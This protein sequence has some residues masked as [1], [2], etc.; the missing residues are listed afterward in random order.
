MLKIDNF[1]GPAGPTGPKGDVGPR[2]P[3]GPPGKS[4]L[5]GLKGDK[6]ERGFDGIYNTGGAASMYGRGSGM[7]VQLGHHLGSSD[8]FSPLV[9][10][11]YIYVKADR[12]Y[13]SPDMDYTL[14]GLTVIRVMCCTK[15]L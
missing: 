12:P 15:L 3:E 9:L 11:W 1:Q 7:Q 14:P 2:G 10:N 13:R 5:D 8:D 6:G 4:G